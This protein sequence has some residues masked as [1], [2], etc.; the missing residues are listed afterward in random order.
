MRICRVLEIDYNEIVFLVFV[1]KSSMGDLV[2]SDG[3]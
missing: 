1:K 2:K 3:K